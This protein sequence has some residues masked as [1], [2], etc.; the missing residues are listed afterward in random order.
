M[1]TI[2]RVYDESAQTAGVRVLVDRLWPRG[3]TKAAARIDEW[4]ED[5]APST[6]LRRWYRHDVTRFDEFRDRYRTELARTPASTAVR[7]LAAIAARQPL[8]LVTATRD[9]DHSGAEVLLEH[10]TDPG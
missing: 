2:R 9:V 7:H 5:A 10:L 6:E 1:I 3:V 8:V 4:L